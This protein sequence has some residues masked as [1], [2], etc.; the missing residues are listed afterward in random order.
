MP[1]VRG[2]PLS[3]LVTPP[4]VPLP[5]TPPT[6]PPSTSPLGT[7]IRYGGDCFAF[8]IYPNFLTFSF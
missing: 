4:Y 6:Y 2:P 3:P 1:M 7:G 8:Q 5:H